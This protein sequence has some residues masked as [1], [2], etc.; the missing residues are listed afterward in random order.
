MNG[1]IIA[2]QKETVVEFTAVVEGSGEIPLIV[3]CDI[4]I[5]HTPEV[6][7]EMI[8]MAALNKVKQNGGM[9]INSAVGMEF[10]PASKLGSPLKF[11][12][13]KIISL[14]A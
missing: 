9:I 12:T 6:G 11:K 14:S 5:G 10:Y 7:D 4:T 13:K 1:N 3:S 2:S 8:M